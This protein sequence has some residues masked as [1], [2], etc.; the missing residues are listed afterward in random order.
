MMTTPSPA[1]QSTA[2]RLI[3]DAAT[4][5]D[6]PA[7]ATA[8][9]RVFQRLRDH[10]ARLIGVV[11]FSTLLARALKLAREGQP[12]LSSIE[13]K[14]DGTIVGLRDALAG[15]SPE[16]ALA[17]PATLLAHFFDLL[18]AFVGDDLTLHL[19]E[20]AALRSGGYGVPRPPGGEE[21]GGKGSSEP[22]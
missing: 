14:P 6:V 22:R 10:L 16:E 17:M 1:F 13:V 11:G 19:V 2:L 21:S 12:A 5:D 18:A 3:R 7:I 4:G 20:E 9:E 15:R 8:A